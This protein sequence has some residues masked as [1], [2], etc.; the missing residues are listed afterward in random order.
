MVNPPF[1]HMLFVLVSVLMMSCGG[2]MLPERFDGVEGVSSEKGHFVIGLYPNVEGSAVGLNSYQLHLSDAQNGAVENA[3]IVVT[4]WMPDH[5]H[6]SDRTPRVF[7][8]NEGL[9]DIDNVVFTMPGRW[10][11][12]LE[13]QVGPIADGVT[14][15]LNVQ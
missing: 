12:N 13:I 8:A 10:Q 14:I 15:E 6:G 5:G 4:P 11:L 9:Y 1:I 2:G 3:T 7:D